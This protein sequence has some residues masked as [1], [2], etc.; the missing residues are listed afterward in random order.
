VSRRGRRTGLLAAAVLVAMGG[1]LAT[2]GTASAHNSLRSTSPADHSTV[3]T[4]P[5]LV[6]LTFDQPAI[7]MGTTVT[8]T[9]PGGVVGDGSVQLIDNTVQQAV[10]PGAPAGAYT[11]VWRVTSADGH[12]IDGIFTFTARTAGAGGSVV[13]TPAPGT[14]TTQSPAGTSTTGAG[15]PT[16][17]WLV[18][19][20]LLVSAL[21]SAA[22]IQR[23][24][25][26]GR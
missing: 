25:R 17:V 9:G 21:T 11:V 14:Q 13:P 23:R 3:D 20:A 7:A 2:A 18:A 16:W 10:R 1:W 8:V 12:P 24:N 19:A 26:R 6:V 5:R 4:V 15:V 22:V